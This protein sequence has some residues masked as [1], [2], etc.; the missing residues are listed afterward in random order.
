[1]HIPRACVSRVKPRPSVCAPGAPV[2]R[3]L[4]PVV[5]WCSPDGDRL[6]TSS[7]D[8]KLILWDVEAAAKLLTM[9]GHS[10]CVYSCLFM[11]VSAPEWRPL[12]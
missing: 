10:D 11:P 6:V 9:S 4:L 1:M 12:P 2:D 8:K 3:T 7:M 5:W